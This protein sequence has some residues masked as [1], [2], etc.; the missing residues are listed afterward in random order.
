[1]Q[2]HSDGGSSG[3]A[4]PRE[5][6]LPFGPQFFQKL[7][8]NLYDGV[9]FVDRQRRILFWNRG[10]ELITGYSREEVLGRH[11]H[12]RIL[13]HVDVQGNALCLKQCP[14]ACTIRDGKP[15]SARV[16]LRHKDGRRIAVDVHIMPLLDDDGQTLGGIEIFRD[17]SSAVALEGAYEQLRVLAERD[18]L[19]GTANRRHLDVALAHQVELLRRTG[20]PFSLVLADV[21]HFKGVND[22]YGHATGDR[23]LVRFAEMLLRLSRPS[24]IVARYGGEE[25]VVILPGQK[26][27][28]ASVV[29]ERFR[30]T[31]P[32]TA[33]IEMRGRMLTASFGITEAVLEDEADDVLRRADEALYR[34]KHGGRNRVERVS[35]T[36]TACPDE[37]NQG[38]PTTSACL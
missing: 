25:F 4:S 1:M 12:A 9:Y 5:P 37:L 15:R 26:I 21:D 13:D 22:S 31:T 20:I 19:T 2:R 7:F 27:E 14:L 28:V 18:P 38:E 29:A 34:A 6:E 33:P 35:A 8:E 24:D 11:C 30:A 23:A 3:S 36:I 10:A 32:Q 17:A 16:F